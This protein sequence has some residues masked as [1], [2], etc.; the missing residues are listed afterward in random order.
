[1]EALSRA[2]KGAFIA[3]LGQR[4]RERFPQLIEKH[5]LDQA[6]IDLVCQRVVDVAAGYGIRDE[7]DVAGF[8][9]CVM[10][11]GPDF[12]RDP[13][14]PWAQATLARPDLSGAQKVALLH[15][16]VVFGLRQ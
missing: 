14:M 6:R 5:G 3:R 13:R 9:D 12:V 4:L 1:M 11:L 8:F 16:H 10:L 15:D 2:A 7:Q